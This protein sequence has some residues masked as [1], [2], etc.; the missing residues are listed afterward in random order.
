MDGVSAN[1]FVIRH[2]SFIRHLTN[3]LIDSNFFPVSQF[4]FK[5]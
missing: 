4:A 1:P 2:F 5:V 3:R